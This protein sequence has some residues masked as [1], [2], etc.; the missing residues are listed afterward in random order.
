MNLNELQEI[1]L[2]NS[3]ELADIR[4]RL[5]GLASRDEKATAALTISKTVIEDALRRF[6]RDGYKATDQR[7][8]INALASEILI[9]DKLGYDSGI[10]GARFI[11]GV[12]E[13]LQGRNNSAL[14]HFKEFISRANTSDPNLRHAHYLAGMICYNRRDYSQASEF[15]RSAFLY[16]PEN[17][18]DWQ[19]LIYVAELAFLDRKPSEEIERAFADAETRLRGVHDLPARHFLWATLY[20]KMGNCYVDIFLQPRRPNLMVNNSLAIAHYKQARK[21]CPDPKYVSPDSLLPVIIDYSIAQALLIGDSVDMDLEQTPQQLLDSV[22]E[23]LRRIVLRKR[24]EIILAQSYFML[25]TC[26]C[27]SVNISKE[28]GEIYLEY[29]RHQTL[30]VPSDLSFYSCISKELLMKDEFVAQIDFYS[31]QLESSREKR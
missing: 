15:F 11:I 5:K 8:L 21:R 1:V 13:L 23:R 30:D 6:D 10:P 25:G 9:F 29:A 12:S 28:M 27:F 17:A 22:F 4:D 20:L 18:C 2:K 26:A 7:L 16:S 19:S 3:A 24:E 14:G 31:K